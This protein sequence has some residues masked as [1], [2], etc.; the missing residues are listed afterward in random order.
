M[1][2]RSAVQVGIAENVKFMFGKVFGWPSMDVSV[3]AVAKRA[4]KGG[5]ICVLGLDGASDA[6]IRLDHSARITRTSSTPDSETPGGHQS[7]PELDGRRRAD[8]HGWE[9]GVGKGGVNFTPTPLTDC[10][11]VG[12]PLKDRAPPFRTGCDYTNKTVSGATET[13]DPGVYCGGLRVTQ[14]GKVKLNAGEYIIDNG[15]L[16]VDT[17]ST[18]QGDDVG[19]DFRGLESNSTSGSIR[20]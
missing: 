1:N 16:V 3:L 10:P 17:G 8:L 14:G 20:R 15:K 4:G 18:L 13:L 2:N 19:F 6:T 7:L 11:Q 12:D 9:V 5:K